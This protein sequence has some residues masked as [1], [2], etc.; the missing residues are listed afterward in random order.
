MLATADQIRRFVAGDDIVFA[1]L[2][3]VD[4]VLTYPFAPPGQVGEFVGRERIRERFG[5]SGRSRQL[6]A[7]DGIDLKVH[8][9]DDPDV[10]VVEIEHH[11]T[12]RATGERYRFPAIGVVRVRG[13]EI[14]SY[15]DYM[16]SG[17]L[18]RL[19]S[20]PEATGR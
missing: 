17:A 19:V 14:V 6:F 15:R 10:M 20:P 12:S 11:G 13:G 9:T 16:D 1:D 2:F 18:R 7:V 3:A 5:P 8:L 4:G